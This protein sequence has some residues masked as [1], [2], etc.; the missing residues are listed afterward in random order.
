MPQ[1]IDLSA[2]DLAEYLD[3]RI[4]DQQIRCVIAV[5]GRIDERRLA[6]AVRLTLDAE[7]VLG[8]HLCERRRR[9][10]WRRREDLDSVTVCSLENIRG[11][12]DGAS[13]IMEFMT[14][15]GDPRSEPLVSVKVMR[16][17]KDTI[18]VRIDHIVSDTGGIKEYLFLLCKTYRRLAE[19]PGYQPLPNTDGR[20]GLVQVLEG[21]SLIE[22]AKSLPSGSPPRARWGF[23]WP[24]RR[25]DDRAFSIRR[26]EAPEFRALKRCGSERDVTVNDLVLTAYYRALM[27]LV[28]AEPGA[29]LCIQVPIDLR[30]YRA[31]RSAETICNLSGQL[32]PV[33][34]RL[35]GEGFGDTLMR[36]SEAMKAFKVDTP[37]IGAAILV[38]AFVAPGLS[39]TRKVYYRMIEEELR[40]GKCNP[41][42]SN[43][44]V[45]SPA[46]L[47]FGDVGVSDAYLVSPLMLAPGFLVGISSFQDSMTITVGYGDADANRPVV[48]RFLDLLESELSHAAG[49]AT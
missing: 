44:G 4:S 13:S 38:A 40:S 28:N 26:L 2:M 35:P 43:L 8:C 18:C 22:K 9:P 49:L 31:E 3:R 46:Q 36:V 47:D 30:R 11:A 14:T 20:R 45:L 1:K 12:D 34:E 48:E 42:L 33:V 15:P 27:E 23:P 16:A 24:G 29:P 41:Y 32:Y 25:D 21:F 6:R 19:D 37:G 5:D 7:P 17:G 39:L 10:Y